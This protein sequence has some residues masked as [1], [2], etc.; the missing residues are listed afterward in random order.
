MGVHVS[1]ASWC[2]TFSHRGGRCGV[3]SIGPLCLCTSVSSA[4]RGLTAASLLRI[5]LRDVSKCLAPCPHGHLVWDLGVAADRTPQLG[6]QQGVAS[7]HAPPPAPPAREGPGVSV[8]RPAMP[9]RKGPWA[10]IQRATC[11]SKGMW[12]AYGGLLCPCVHP[13]GEQ[14]PDRTALSL[15]SV[16]APL[17]LPG[18]CLSGWEAGTSFPCCFVL[19]ARAATCTRQP[20]CPGWASLSSLPVCE[21]HV[22]ESPFP[23]AG[24]EKSLTVLSSPPPQAVQLLRPPPLSFSLCL[25]VPHDL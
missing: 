8:A 11:I 22:L 1:P 12:Q 16:L 3:T 25:S 20:P 15:S 23:Q 19:G 10:A 24:P 17:S 21:Y 9:E 4:T 5:Q 2:P 6:L 18:P 14:G 7:S 13:A